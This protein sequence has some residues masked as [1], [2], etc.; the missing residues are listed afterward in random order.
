MTSWPTMTDYQ[1][2]MQNPRYSFSDPELQRGTPVLNM[3]GLPKPI[4]GAFASVYQIASG[5]HQYAV[6]CFLRYHADQAQRYAAISNYL[7]QV[8]LP[9]T[10]EFNLQPK[11]IRMRGEWFPLLKMEWINGQSLDGYIEQH[12]DHPAVLRNLADRF[13][14]MIGDLGR[15]SIAHGDLQHGNI[16]IVNHQFLLID[17]DG[18]YVPT[19]DGMASHELGH[20]NYQHPGRQETDFG[21]HIDNFSAWV[22]YL[23]LMALS[24][25]PALWRT[26]RAG[27]ECLLF[28]QHDFQN[29]TS[30]PAMKAVSQ[31]PD[32]NVHA[33][34][35][36]FRTAVLSDFAQIPSILRNSA[37]TGGPERRLVSGLSWLEDYVRPREQREPPLPPTLPEQPPAHAATLTGGSSWVLDYLDEP[38]EPEPPA[39]QTRPSDQTDLRERVV[40]GTYGLVMHAGFSAVA[41]GA[42]PSSLVGI[43]AGGGV[44]LIA[45]YLVLQYS[46]FPEVRH[47][48]RLLLRR[49]RLR[50]DRAIAGQQLYWNA[51]AR[52][53]VEGEEQQ[54]LARLNQNLNHYIEVELRRYPVAY[55]EIPGIDPALAQRLRAAGVMS[56]ADVT[57]WRV[58][59][60]PGVDDVRA[61]ALVRWRQQL[62]T[63]L[64]TQ[65]LQPLVSWQMSQKAALQNVYGHKRRTLTAREVS[66]QQ[67]RAYAVSDLAR[68]RDELISYRDVNFRTYLRWVFSG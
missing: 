21:P 37:L 66:F 16:L 55:H 5:G 51:I 52:K 15:A 39:A 46:L 54:Q 11:G 31:V 29:I 40:I 22:I 44:I 14:K 49:V 68:I 32:R 43:T 57:Y 30:S 7:Q 58:E 41:L 38:I 45:V 56:A 25:Q 53:R 63:R 36:R 19:L 65:K 27:D 47:K 24:V 13:A 50:W 60:V 33:L 67:R 4:T 9:Y 18:M 48:R 6:R 12:L 26:L 2:A 34:A 59:Q 61:E 3:L 17:Y 62:E 42:L 1:E 10:V 23:S 8:R 20:R 35:E 64:K 28:R